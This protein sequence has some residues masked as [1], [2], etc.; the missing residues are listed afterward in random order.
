ML[1]GT[2]LQLPPT[3]CLPSVNVLPWQ[4]L[5][6]QRRQFANEEKGRTNGQVVV[7]GE[8][9]GLTSNRRILAVLLAASANNRG[10]EG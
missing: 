5:M 4:K 3:T 7:R 8:R 2:A 10:I 1:T 9:S 6:L